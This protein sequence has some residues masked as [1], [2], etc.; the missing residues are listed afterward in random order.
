MAYVQRPGEYRLSHSRLG[1]IPPRAAFS[2]VR[3][4]RVACCS[5]TLTIYQSSLIRFKSLLYMNTTTALDQ[6]WAHQ[7][8]VWRSKPTL[9][10]IKTHSYLPSLEFVWRQSTS[11]ESLHPSTVSPEDTKPVNQAWTITLLLWL[12]YWIWFIFLRFGLEMEPLLGECQQQACQQ[13]QQQTEDYMEMISQPIS[14]AVLLRLL[15]IGCHW[16]FILFWLGEHCKAWSLASYLT[17]S[18][19]RTA[20]ATIALTISRLIPA[21]HCTHKASVAM[22][23][24][25]VFIS[26]GIVIQCCVYC[27]AID[28]NWSHV[29]PYK[30]KVTTPAASLRFGCEFILFFFGKRQTLINVL[31]L[32]QPK[33]L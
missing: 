15:S 14:R 13:Q 2:A 28:K 31:F 30:C 22:A 10:L 29:P 27:V 8:L 16:S 19:I 21:S 6:H 24:L 18:I 32:D 12:W 26:L 4:G 11:S 33:S 7:R 23:C 9:P 17:C 25:S 20:K 5:S 1:P 3:Q